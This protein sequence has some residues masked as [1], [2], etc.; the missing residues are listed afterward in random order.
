M[1]RLTSWM[2]RGAMLAVLGVAGPAS[3]GVGT[4]SAYAATSIKAVVNGQ[5]ITT[6]QIRQRAAFLKLRRVGGNTTQKATE[7]LIDE[8][9]K[10]QEIER[11]GVTIPDQA[12]EAAYENFAKG[13]KLST[14]QLAQVLGQAGFSPEAFKDYIRVQ[15]GWGQ[16]VAKRVQR[17]ERL[18]E[19]DVVQRMLARGGEKPSTT[20][21]NL[22]QVIFVIPEGQRG[23][24]LANRKR[25]AAAMRSRFRSCDTTYDIAKG[26]RDVTVRD[27]GRVAQ[28]ELPPIWKDDVIGTD[29]GRA[30]APKE[31][32]RGVEFIAV[33]NARTI[34]DDRAAQ[35]VF[36]M[37]DMEALNKGQDG[38]DAAVL[39]TL[40]EEAQIVRR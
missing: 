33:C 2:M 19:Q 9:L 10:K 25:E 7:E 27:L 37:Q 31:T 17:E 5:P 22:Q 15:M 32:D 1:Q 38:P 23:A 20:E 40:R 16:A 28:P 8:A 34:S 36:Q 21:Y 30:T 35:M 6:Y 12:I 14:A 13:N 3:I 29:P 4:P 24:L 11:Q 18:S 26:L 39:K